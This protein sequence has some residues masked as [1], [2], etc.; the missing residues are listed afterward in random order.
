MKTILAFSRHS[1][2]REAFKQLVPAT[3]SKTL[4]FDN[5]LELKDFV[6]QFEKPIAIVEQKVHEGDAAI[7]QEV[8]QAG[9]TKLLLLTD[10]EEEWMVSEPQIE[11]ILLPVAHQHL[12]QKVQAYLGN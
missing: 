9:L 2:W 8:L 6:G 12:S 3:T 5:L 11:V 7:I 1:L 4:V 10:R